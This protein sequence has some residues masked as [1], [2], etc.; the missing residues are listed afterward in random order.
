MT[1]LRICHDD[2]AY[3]YNEVWWR[4]RSKG[5]DRSGEPIGKSMRYSWLLSNHKHYAPIMVGMDKGLVQIKNHDLSP[6]R[7]YEE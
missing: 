5:I 1:F 3:P 6:N 7:I 4:E 2:K